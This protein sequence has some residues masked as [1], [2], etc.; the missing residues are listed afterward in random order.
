M[1]NGIKPLG[2][3]NDPGE[4]HAFLIGFFE[5]TCPWPAARPICKKSE[6]EIKGEYHY[7]VGGRGAG[8]VILLLIL[9]ALAKLAKEVL[10]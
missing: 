3:F 2:L 1:F 8:L 7:Y 6:K 4:G 9:L 5:V 10:L